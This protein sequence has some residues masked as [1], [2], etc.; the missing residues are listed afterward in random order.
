MILPTMVREENRYN[1]L[2]L[3]LSLS[4]K[5]WRREQVSSPDCLR[6]R[7]NVELLIYSHSKM[8]SER[9]NIALEEL[10]REVQVNQ[11]LQSEYDQYHKRV[12]NYRKE[13]ERLHLLKQEYDIIRA[14]RE[15]FKNQLI[16]NQHGVSEIIGLYREGFHEYLEVIMYE[17][18]SPPIPF[19]MFKWVTR[20][21]F[22]NNGEIPLPSE[23]RDPRYQ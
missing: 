11:Q 4:L 13:I 16:D 15:V 22:S 3:N 14:K 1:L 5:L 18:V 23:Y 21:W 2:F 6:K 8:T 9:L 17:D 10:Q 19:S 7:E 12:V 20:R